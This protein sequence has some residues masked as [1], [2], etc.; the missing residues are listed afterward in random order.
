MTSDACLAKLKTLGGERLP[1]VL[2]TLKRFEREIAALDCFCY[3]V[4]PRYAESML[5]DLKFF[6]DFEMWR[7][8][9]AYVHIRIEEKRE[10]LREITD[11]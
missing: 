10:E 11:L 6:G 2:D 5:G 7:W 3:P 4:V 8:A 9:D 1:G